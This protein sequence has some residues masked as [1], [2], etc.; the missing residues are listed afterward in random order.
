MIT[1]QTAKAAFTLT[2]TNQVLNFAFLIL[3][4][5][6]IAVTAT[7]SAG[8]DSLL[9]LNTHYTV[10]VDAQSITMIGGTATD[11]IS[12]CRATLFTQETEGAANNQFP[13]AGFEASLDRLV[14]QVQ[15]LGLM[16]DRSLRLPNSAAA[17]STMTLA[18]RTS[19]VVGFDS[20]GALTFYTITSGVVSAISG[21][22]TAN[23]VLINGGSGAAT[24]GALIFT[25]P[26]DIATTSAVR[27]GRVGIGQVAGSEND[28]AITRSVPTTTAQASVV[29]SGS[30][31][32][33]YDLHPN[34]FRDTTSFTPTVAADAYASFDS[35]PSMGGTVNTNHFRGFQFRGGYSGSGTLDNMSGFNNQSS[36]SGGT[37]SAIKMFHCV[38]P[39]ITGGATVTDVF[40]LYVDD[41]GSAGTTRHAIYTN[42]T[43][44]WFSAG[45]RIFTSALLTTPAGATT[46]LMGCTFDQA[47]QTGMAVMNKSATATGTLVSFCNSGGTVQGTITQTNST[48]VAYNTTSDGRL[49]LNVRPILNSGAII[50]AMVPVVHDWV[51]GGTNAHGFI[52]QELHKVYPDAVV[53]GDAGKEVENAW[54]IDYSKL[55]PILTAEIKSLRSRLAAIN[56]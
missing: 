10:D 50:D 51:W 14:M 21:Q 18:D 33:A 49:K 17:V 2:T 36:V 38:Q 34:A 43:A 8:V 41:L 35:L 42:G 1:S 44:P 7:T 47:T 40:G 26:Q 19:N 12:I 32:A 27:F 29:V 45:G 46:C 30:L 28:L 11:V 4:A 16:A 39:S 3:E 20:N 15:R 25:L 13:S 5:A 37:V 56:A 22:G 48:T 52:A 6:D 24:T 55:V 9:V 54:G 23:Q 31:T 53:V